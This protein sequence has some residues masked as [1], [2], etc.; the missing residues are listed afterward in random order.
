[1]LFPNGFIVKL[2]TA[3]TLLTLFISNGVVGQEMLDQPFTINEGTLRT[4]DALDA[5]S[6]KT[7]YSFTYDSRLIDPEKKV[8]LSFDQTPLREVLRS[9]LQNDSLEF[10]LIDKYIVISRTRKEGSLRSSPPAVA[11]FISGT[12]V[13]EETGEP[14]PF[15][16]IGFKNIQRGTVTNNNGGFGLNVPSQSYD[17]TLYVSYLGYIER[18]I[19]VEQASGSNMVIKMRREYIS[20]P[21][22]IIRNQIPQDIIFKAYQAIPENYG[23]TPALMTGFYREGVLRKNELQTYSEAILKI[24]KSP[25]STSFQNDQIV[26]IKSRKIENLDRSDTLAVRLKA[27]LSTSLELDGA[28]NFYD[29]INPESIKDYNF[30]LTDIV[31]YGDESAY[32]IEF[33]SRQNSEFSFFR[34]TIFINTYDFGILNVDFEITPSRIDKIKESFISSSSGGFVT[35]PVSVKYNVTYRK[36]GNRYFLSHVRGDLIFASKQKRKLFNSQFKV[37]FELAITGTEL[38][39]VK[40]FDREELAPIH[41]VFSETIKTYDKSFWKDMDFL[42]PEDNL[43]E[44]LKNMKAKLM[45]FSE[46]DE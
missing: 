41:S 1:M 38:E 20:I 43:L 45:E 36:A 14:L 39:N 21:E 18:K 5:V 23:K 37:F 42:R 44:A 30:R 29:F 24:Y 10:S 28:R 33:E 35:W 12:I 19:P 34:G 16:T 22:I 25:Y 40:R 3:I 46:G 13:D 26:V 27:G 7:G 17:D 32:A 31:R 2:S 6:L 4:I 15:A 11:G 9:I 8:R